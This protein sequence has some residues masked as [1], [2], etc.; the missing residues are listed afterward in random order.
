MQKILF[1]G[2]HLGKLS[3]TTFEA[4]VGHMYHASWRELKKTLNDY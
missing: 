4:S 3:D 2:F 1:H